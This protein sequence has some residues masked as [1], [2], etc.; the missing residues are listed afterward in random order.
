MQ[1][2]NVTFHMGNFDDSVHSWT[3]EAPSI[4]KATTQA[5][6]MLFDLAEK[7]EYDYSDVTSIEIKEVE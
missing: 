7:T 6:Q 2:F 1:K 5:S 4:V 3:I